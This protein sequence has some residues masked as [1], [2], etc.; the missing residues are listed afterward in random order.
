MKSA[1]I[2]ILSNPIHGALVVIQNLNVTYIPDNNYSGEDNV[3]YKVTDGEWESNLSQITITIDE[4]YDSPIVSNLYIDMIEDESTLISLGAYDT[5]SN[6]D[7]LVFSIIS[8]PTSGTLV[9]QRATA[10][11]LYTPNLNYNGA[12]G[13]IYEVTD[14]ANTSQAEVFINIISR[15]NLLLIRLLTNL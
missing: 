5:D 9:E 6:D 15:G 2:I 11:Y 8:G 10:S 14:G 7:N 13:F 4:S 1:G 12:D 3:L